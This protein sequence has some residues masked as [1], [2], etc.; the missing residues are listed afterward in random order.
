MSRGSVSLE[1]DHILEK[2]E[3]PFEPACQETKRF[4]G[5]FEQFQTN[6]MHM[7]SESGQK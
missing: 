2:I 6:R 4:V 1:F 3:F 5:S 7:K